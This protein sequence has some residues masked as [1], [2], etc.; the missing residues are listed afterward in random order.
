MKH[1]RPRWRKVWRDL[2]ASFTRAAL[3]VITLAIGI[4]TVSLLIN[5]LSLLQTGFDRQ[6][7]AVS[8]SSATLIIPEGFDLDFVKAV[9]KMPALQEAEG[10][11]S[12]N[13]RLNVGANQWLTLNLSAIKDF[14]DIRID[15][16]Q[17]FS[18]A[19]PPAKGEILLERSSLRLAAMPEVSTGDLLTVQTA[20]GQ[21]RTLKFS[22]VA[23]D[24]NRTPSAG[25]GIIYG[26]IALETL[27]GLG[28]P[29]DFNE[30]RLVVAQDK[31]N[32]NYIR[33]VAA[34]VE[35]RVEVSGR[36]V[37]A[38]VVP[39]PGQHPLGTALDG[40]EIILG[41]LSLLTLIGGG[42]LVF[43]TIVA[44]LAQQV[45]QIGVMKAI[46]GRAR[47]FVGM[48]FG[49]VSVLGLIALVLAAPLAFV[50]S[51]QFATFLADLFN[52]D[53]RGVQVS[54]GALL[55]EVLI[56]F[57]V[58]LLAALYPTWSGTRVTVLQAL[59][60]Y[61][62]SNADGDGLL[63]RWL[64]KL[65][66]PLFPRPVLLSLR[67]TFRR[68]ARLVLTLLPLILSGAILISVVNLRDSLQRDLGDIF[69]YMRY[70]L[71]A[72][73][74]RPYRLAEIEKAAL[75][76]PGITRVEGYQMTTDAYR[77]GSD[78]SQMDNIAVFGL[79]PT[80]SFFELPVLA[81]RWLMPQDR[82]A[83][84]VNDVFLRD[85]PDV[86][87]GDEVAFEINGRKVT[88]QIVGIVRQGMAPATLYLNESY[89][90]ETL[91]NVGRV[92]NLWVVT[93]PGELPTEISKFLEAQFEQANLNITSLKT[94]D[95]QRS[96]IEF[97]FNI[98]IVPLGGAVVLLALVG[99]LGLMSTMSTNVLER[100]REIGVTRAIGANDHSV[101]QIFIVEGLFIALISWLVS[102]VAALPISY[103]LGNLVG[104][105]FLKVP[106]SFTVSLEGILAWLLIV[107]VT[108]AVSCYLPAREA[109]QTS[110]R[111][112][113]AY[114]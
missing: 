3:V 103:L 69:A 13:L 105:R 61:G 2:S 15:K 82:A 16:V 76:V 53:L 74:E 92:N 27:K 63:N 66:G 87:L 51:I 8:P 17:S 94:V 98:M 70:D 23:F 4:F 39:E 80:T 64:K 33:T 97:H 67:N 43:N 44:L 62:S 60:D 84:V 49:M 20:N 106:L 90:A 46:G 79:S 95:A 72:S 34:Q 52:L 75:Q 35:D 91:G 41:T 110:T 10:R 81:G 59:S 5:T 11:R 29:M 31:L 65:R 38:T 71:A 21:V 12:V 47:Q 42:F 48:Y 99:G 101:Q 68:R 7:A 93:D 73:F 57:G 112:L 109:S 56:G 32:E 28:E 102:V 14:D 18:G 114:E 6:Y 88:L 9:R 55:V 19:W 85:E 107:V 77:P 30:L 100:Q 50:S 54:T 26:Y 37:G 86:A 1:L 45:R 113:L 83:V 24:F 25:T 36:T 58:P 89:F 22:G 96:F 111:R 108:A 78:E 40:I 104:L